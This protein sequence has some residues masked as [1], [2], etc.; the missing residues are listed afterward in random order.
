MNTELRHELK[1]IYWK[2]LGLRAVSGLVSFL[3]IAAWVFVVVVVWTAL[4]NEPRLWQTVWVS[5]MTLVLWLGLFGYFVVY[6][7][8]R[9]PR[10]SRL[11]LEVESRKDFKHI[12][13]AGYEFSERNDI[14]ERYS[15]EL[16][17]EVVRRAA[18]SISGLQVRFLFLEKRQLFVVPATY[19]VLIVMIALAFF[20]PTA[21][22]EAG[23]RLLAPED[24]AAVVG[25]A[26]LFGSP[27]DITVL[28]GSDVEVKA[29][30]F[31]ESEET[32]ALSYNLSEGFWKT[33][34]TTQSDAEEFGGSLLDTYTF[35]FRDIR[36]SVNYYFQSG[37]VKSPT[38]RI[39]VVHKPIV[40]ALNVVLTPPEYTGEPADTLVDSGGNIQ[41]LEGTDV[42][43]RA[44]ANNTLTAAMVKFGS[45]DMTP[46]DVVGKNFE[47]DFVALDD[48]SYS[49]FLED[50]A[51]HKTDDPLVYSIEVYKDNPP[52]LDVLEPG[53]EATLPR[54]LTVDVGFIASDDYGVS[55][56][57]VFYRKNGE[58]KFRRRPIPLRDDT[59]KREIAKAF[60][61]D[62]SDVPLFPGN[63]IEYFLQVVDNNVVTG[64]GITKSPVFHIAVP[65]MADLFEKIKEEDSKRSDLLEQTVTES[66][67]LKDRLE[68]LSREFKKT[69]KMDWAQKKEV[70]K[71]ISSQE[72][73][74]EKLTDI[75]QSLEETLQSL[76]DN[77]MTSQEIGD[78]LEEI[79]RLIDD[80]NDEALNKYVEELREAMEKLNPDEIQK[81]LENLNVSAEELLESLE[82]TESLLKQIQQEQQ[83]EELVRETKSLMDEQEELS[84]KTSEAE[85][86][87]SDK[88]NEL[89]EDQEGLSE[90]AQELAD[91]LQ[92]MAEQAQ[93]DAEAGDMS[94]D[95]SEQMEQTSQEFSESGASESMEEASDELKQGDKQQAQQSQ[96][97]A[98]DK[99]IALFTRLASMQMQMNAM[100]QQQT[101]GNLQRLAKSTLALSFKQEALTNRLRDQVA[102]DETSDVRKLAND[103]QMY[104]RGVEQIANELHEISRRSLSVS[105]SLLQLLGETVNNM[106]NTTLFL[107]Q[108]KAFMGAASASQAVTSLNQATIEL[109]TAAQSS[110]QGGGSGSMDKQ[111]SAMQQ[112]MQQQQQLLQESKALLQMRA[113][114]E[115]LLQERQAAIE[116]L[117]GQQRS[118]QDTAKKM[119]KDLKD[120]KRILGRM[121]KVQEEMQEVIR[122]L[123]SGVL[124]E[125]T[126]RNEERILSRLLDANRSVHSRDYEKKRLSTTGED[127]F[128]DANDASMSKPTSQLLREEI[129]RAMSLK[130]PGE[131]EDLIKLYFRALAEEASAATTGE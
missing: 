58:E 2:T 26:N 118:I 70:D 102:T 39:N 129:R 60:E 31:G 7:L 45:G 8:T 73:I 17:R 114:Q 34:Q 63:Y 72:Q 23:E 9:M 78:K 51:G 44:L 124:D 100:A 56:A 66:K 85:A 69:E 109:L 59:G 46:V 27:G 57:S 11:A 101:G 16:V 37:E 55:R 77:Q 36:S 88:M 35:T 76:S 33:E 96:E 14:S 38:Y 64:P 49:I 79:K 128:S 119:E 20:S 125:Q 113:A 82:R 86:G 22:F 75:Q 103:Q 80:I 21:L 5:R 112:M 105:E 117:A 61:W 65:T 52:V 71:A 18:K 120:N 4:T 92:E 12:V 1:K 50:D 10:F 84:D 111:M 115:K 90:K 87:D 40:T 110:M 91:K 42:S 94:E 24:V 53:P 47:F 74:E 83:M 30:D 28:A 116:R 122:D 121:D 67:D 89:A 29:F 62:L 48:G 43:V 99:M 104:T 127:I 32:V 3:T 25:K 41:A 126:I 13:A 15:P 97:Q 98:M 54:N 68:K 19:L 107:E 95:L 108:N 130:A 123:E 6:P 93:A 106:R 131:F 81:A